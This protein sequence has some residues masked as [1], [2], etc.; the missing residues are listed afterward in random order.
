MG[1]EHNMEAQILDMYAQ[2]V[3]PE[4]IMR[5]FDITYPVLVEIIFSY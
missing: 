5:V 1:T 3:S 4:I 2:G